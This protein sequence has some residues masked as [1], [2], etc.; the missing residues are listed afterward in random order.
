MARPPRIAYS[1]NRGRRRWPNDNE[2]RA[3]VRAFL[4]RSFKWMI[5]KTTIP[6]YNL[7]RLKCIAEGFYFEIAFDADLRIIVAKKHSSSFLLPVG[8]KSNISDDVVYKKR[9]K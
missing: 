7:D 4:I 5:N 2:K 3:M 6:Y 8:C 9:V 1:G